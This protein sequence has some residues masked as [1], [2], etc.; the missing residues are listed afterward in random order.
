MRLVKT[1]KRVG[2][3]MLTLAL[4]AGMMSVMGAFPMS[5]TA[6]TDEVDKLVIDFYQG[7]DSKVSLTWAGNANY[8]ALLS[9]P[10][11][12]PEAEDDHA[13]LS[14]RFD[15]YKCYTDASCPARAYLGGDSYV[16]TDFM[17][18]F[19]Y[20]Q[21]EVVG[22]NGSDRGLVYTRENQN[23]GELFWHISTLA[24]KNEGKA[25]DLK[26]F[27]ATVKFAMHNDTVTGG[28]LF[29]F[30]ESDPGKY[31]FNFNYT[32]RYSTGSVLAIGNAVN[33]K[34]AGNDAWKFFDKGAVIEDEYLYDAE[35]FGTTLTNSYYTLT[36]RAVNGA[37]T[38]TVTDNAG[39][40]VK[41]M[42]Q[43]YTSTNGGIS[44]GFSDRDVI[45]NKIT[46]TELDK[47][48]NEVDLGFTKAYEEAY[49][50]ATKYSADFA[51]LNYQGQ[52]WEGSHDYYVTLSAPTEESST[53]VNTNHEW[54]S[55]R[56][57][58]YMCYAETSYANVP[59]RTYFGQA[60]SVGGS[61]FIY[62]ARKG[63][64]GGADAYR[65][66]ML[67][68]AD[69][70]GELFKSINTLVPKYDGAVLNVKNFEATVKFAMIGTGYTGGLLFGFHEEHAG[71]Y[72]YNTYYTQRYHSGSML[73]IGNA[74]DSMNVG[75]TDAWKFYDKGTLVE[76]SYLT[77][78]DADLGRT[79]SAYWYTLTVKAV[80]GTVTFTLTGEDGY[81]TTM[82]KE[83]T[84][85]E[86]GI[87][88]GL[89]GRNI[90]L[91]AIKVVELN[92]KGIPVNV[93][94]YA[95][96]DAGN[97]TYSDYVTTKDATCTE[98]G[99]KT[100]TCTVCG[101]VDVQEIPVIPHT[102]EYVYNNDATTEADG[103][104]TGTCSVCG[105]EDTITAEGTKIDGFVANF[106]EM[107]EGAIAAGGESWNGLQWEPSINDAWSNTAANS[108]P[109][110]ADATA[111]DKYASS[112]MSERFDTVAYYSGS[113][114]TTLSWFAQTVPSEVDGSDNS[115]YIPYNHVSIFG[116]GSWLYYQFAVSGQPGEMLRVIT[117]M[118]AKYDEERVNVKNFEAELQ[119]AF[120]DADRK[121]AVVMSFHEETAG[122][123]T[124]LN[125]ASSIGHTGNT[126]VI[127]NG[128]DIAQD[129][130]SFYT[131]E[132]NISNGSVDTLFGKTLTDQWYTLKVKVL[133]GTATITLTG[134]DGVE[135]GSITKDVTTTA[136]QISFG[137][138]DRNT[139][140][141]SFKV[142][143]LDANDNVV[144]L[145]TYATTCGVG[146]HT[147][148]DHMDTEC[149]VCHAIRTVVGAEVDNGNV[150]VNV[151]LK[152]GEEIK[153]AIWLYSKDYKNDHIVYPVIRVGFQENEPSSNRYQ[154][155][156][157]EDVTID[158]ADFEVEA[159][160]I[161]P[162]KE[163]PNIASAGV[164]LSEKF[165]EGNNL[166]FV[167][168][169]TRVE[170]ED[171]AAYVVLGG[172][173]YKL[174]DYGVIVASH[175]GMLVDLKLS[176]LDEE[177]YGI[178]EAEMVF[179][180]K[181]K[182][183]KVISFVSEDA[184]LY[185]NCDAYVDLALTLTNIKNK[186]IDMDYFTRPYIRVQDG[187]NILTL[188]GG[189]AYGAYS[190]YQK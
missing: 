48:G 104:K 38:F 64:G 16:G 71:K 19:Y 151:T 5:A 60:D 9:N 85:T 101:H 86:G 58:S 170:G 127:G 50:A 76:T 1:L 90:L 141:K 83:Y 161:T 78:V 33:S 188:Y 21:R 54:L 175:A 173:E 41:T 164:S 98:V 20:A 87:S 65:G 2:A 94:A 30:H 149:N 15:S 59:Q 155:V 17:G 153:G 125:S 146:N 96:C 18:Y 172:E 134:A 152:P 147:F 168:R 166:R 56:F 113:E 74:V 189:L 27:E 51:E 181:L 68:N 123:Y 112:W 93:G 111:A 169:F 105:H 177:N 132:E 67:N 109:T 100:A 47:D 80:N 137:V 66:L 22:T 49:A 4:L 55:T 184:P 99:S 44:L 136:G 148:D 167:S 43:S 25:L 81:K 13:W 133:D 180:T 7:L 40:V 139:H 118:A 106:T 75:S 32:E 84:S 122:K 119:F 187:E 143:E 11:E 103:T 116:G 179:D 117:S 24:L 156:L 72:A 165:T 110:A 178:V 26:N 36:V 159:K 107:A 73:A 182:Y 70:S 82:T 108:D 42:S 23:S 157:P 77:N 45:V 91:R 174:L 129:G 163:D 88:I 10:A 89:S 34:T 135:V 171:G 186:D 92:S 62:A 124:W 120:R 144:D 162:T 131:K 79:L 102:I 57:D 115:R 154:V 28:L 61:H 6:E 53:Q 37:A 121:G 130:W 158:L 69:T 140:I 35:S 12:K 126:V 176:E 97:H 39:A 8:T 3:V 145:G 46:V 185:D 29:G 142:A 150:Y 128:S 114:P 31:T 138:S 63:F 160:I 14:E 190:T 95:A 52:A 183:T